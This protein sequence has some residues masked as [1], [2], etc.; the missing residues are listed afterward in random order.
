MRPSAVR[1]GLRREVMVEPRADGGVDLLDPLYERIDHLDAATV[2]ALDAGE[3]GALEALDDRLLRESP[4][5][6]AAR[7]AA[8][9]A[10]LRP[11]PCAPVVPRAEL[12]GV[13]AAVA[14]LGWGRAWREPERWR[15]WVEA[16]RAGNLLLPLEGLLEPEHAAAALAQAEA[17][18]LQPLR[19]AVV[20]ANRAVVDDTVGGALGALRA[21]LGDPST[22]VAVGAALGRSLTGPLHLNLWRL[23]PGERMAVHPD[24]ARYAGTVAIGLDREWTAGDG[25][26]IAFGDPGPEGLVVRSRWLPH[27]GD[28]LIFAPAAG[29]WHAVEPPVSRP[30]WTLSGWWF[31]PPDAP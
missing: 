26:A 19:S 25:G 17:L 20:S 15:R 14:A 31:W 30:R 13:A 10:R 1:W 7:R 2:R 29:T 18:P 4:V 22:R 6:D 24:G 3:P 8:W 11:E 9:Y 16:G 23:A 5:A 27:L 28:A 12:S 21:L